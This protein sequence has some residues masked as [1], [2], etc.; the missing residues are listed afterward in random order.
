MATLEIEVKVEKYVN[1]NVEISHVI[2]EI[3]SVEM[4]KRWTY[5]G[6]IINGIQLDISNLTDEQ[7]EIIK[8]YLTD[9]IKLF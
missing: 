4:K 3:N 5:V 6:Q 1:V 7:K 9:K 2:E 8:K